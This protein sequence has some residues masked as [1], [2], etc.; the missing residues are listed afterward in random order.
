MAQD[1]TTFGGHRGPLVCGALGRYDRER[2]RR[3]A[4]AL[5]GDDVRLRHEDRTSALAMDR[6]P[7]RWGYR[8]QQGLGW[9][10]GV[11]WR[12]GATTWEEAST[13]GACGLVLDG[14][15]R[16]LH[17][18]IN[19][20]GAVY[21]MVDGDALYF[22]SRIDP[23]VQTSPRLL[24]IDWDAWA[25][26]IAV[27]FPAADRT[28]FAEVRRL[29]PYA[30]LAVR[31]G[32]TLVESPPWPWAHVEQH[33]DRREAGAALAQSL[34]ETVEA[35]GRPVLVPLSGGR[36]SRMLACAF[37]EAGLAARAVSVADDEGDTHEE[38]LARPVAEAL[39]LEQGRLAADPDDYP[40]SWQ[41]RARL[42]EHQFVDHAWLVPLSRYVARQDLPISDGLAMDT[43]LGQG[44]R[45]FLPE[46]LE[47]ADPARA[48]LALFDSMR[49][50]GRGHLALADH[51]HGPVEDRARTLFLSVAE[52]FHGAQ[53]QTRLTFY[54][55][56]TVRGVA[57]YATGLLGQRASVVAPAISNDFAVASLA[58]TSEAR[59]LDHLYV[60]TFDVLAPHIGRMP[61][62]ATAERQA[63]HLPR[64][65][66]SDPAVEAH[67]RRIARGPL[68]G[69]VSP[70]LRDWLRS[71]TRGELSPDLR[72]GMEAISLLHSWWWRYRDRLH[73]VD[74][75]D[76]VG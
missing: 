21:W 63:P 69:L 58:A 64:V 56:R 73:E 8:G 28:P 27:R 16:R 45:F 57:S 25:S 2:V 5:G 72:L 34:R 46:T 43:M 61:S 17:S 36:D 47:R 31:R 1:G 14:R 49:R 18:S 74:V 50:Y 3:M 65:W 10:E 59:E 66:R 6:E 12:P 54:R 53:E 20:I 35:V 30:T 40:A 48:S 55:T 19:G 32:R 42:V 75:K 23:L 33:L 7:L 71:P 11:P 4:T 29:E 39:G 70:D 67:R 44:T 13:A 22:A 24:S 9:I 76:L 26:I 68:R 51:L 38:D 62:T 15:H 37:A 60:A 52:Q 41:A